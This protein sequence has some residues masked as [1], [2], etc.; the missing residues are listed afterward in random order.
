MLNEDDAE[1]IQHEML[2]KNRAKQSW[3]PIAH[4]DVLII[5][6]SSST[7]EVFCGVCVCVCVCFRACACVLESGY[8][9]WLV[10]WSM[11]E[12]VGGEQVLTTSGLIC[13]LRSG[14]H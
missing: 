11:C 5:L 8:L 9:S 4:A 1:F 2:N 13:F 7:L 3:L 12:D 10:P 14:L 6:I